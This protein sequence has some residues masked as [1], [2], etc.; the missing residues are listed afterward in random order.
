MF[1]DLLNLHTRPDLFSTYSVDTLWTNP[2]LSQQ[3]LSYHLDQNTPLASR[4]L[5]TIDEIVGWI[6]HHVPLAGKNICDLGCGPG[7]YAKQFATKGAQVIG[8][9]FSENSI[10][11]A[12]SRNPEI[13]FQKTDYLKDELPSG[14]DIISLIYCDLCPLSSQNRSLLFQKIHKSLQNDGYFIFD[15]A[16]EKAFSSITESHQYGRNYMD[17]FWS[18]N[19][20]FAFHDTFTYDSK[21]S[22]DRF[23]IIEP[24]KQWSVCNWMQYFNHET[25]AAE[26]NAHGFEIVHISKNFELSDSGMNVLSIIAKPI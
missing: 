19:D 21:A 1:A 25:I 3:M 13:R 17:G 11:Y 22:L 8:L 10:A 7:L 6:D 23:T 2:H 24:E 26:L 12:A 18:A 20:Y 9:D 14:M 16:D 4:P 15:V 5:K